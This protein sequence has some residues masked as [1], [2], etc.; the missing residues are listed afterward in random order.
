MQQL[1]VYTA[2][3]DLTTAQIVINCT[4]KYALP[5]PPGLTPLNNVA[6]TSCPWLPGR[7]AQGT[8]LLLLLL[9]R[10]LLHLSMELQRTLN[11]GRSCT[12]VCSYRTLTVYI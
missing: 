2:H 11:E 12:R 4:L 5:Q 6:N 7:L 9:L 3:F 8:V 10:L 1:R